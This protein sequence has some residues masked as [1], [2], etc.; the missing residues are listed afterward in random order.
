MMRADED[1]YCSVV[2]G[3]EYYQFTVPRSSHCVHFELLRNFRYTVWSDVRLKTF[4][5]HSRTTAN[6]KHRLE[7]PVTVYQKLISFI[8][9]RYE[10][11]I[12]WN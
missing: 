2:V 1:N 10:W 3:R 5:I 12:A 11:S 7:N 9:Q 4:R 6:K 8:Q